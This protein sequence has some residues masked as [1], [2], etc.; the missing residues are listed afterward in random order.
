MNNIKHITLNNTPDLKHFIDNAGD[1]LD[2]FRYFNSRDITCIENHIVTILI[3]ND[4]TPVAYGHLDPDGEKVWLGVC[5][6]EKYRKKGYG[7]L[8]M[9]E[10][11]THAGN[12]E[13]KQIHL[14]VD[15]DNGNAIELY[16]KVGFSIN[17]ELK[18]DVYLMVLNLN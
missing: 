5:V 16:K 9:R 13:I 1:S 7:K 6:S 14:T 15:S 18:K 4:T 3:Y 2:S 11:I 10:L 12:M 8:I 17:S